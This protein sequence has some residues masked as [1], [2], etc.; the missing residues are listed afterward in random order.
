MGTEEETLENSTNK[1]KP[2][3]HLLDPF[4]KNTTTSVM[5]KGTALDLHRPLFKSYPQE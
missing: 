5:V 1:G 2:S 4:T 3:C